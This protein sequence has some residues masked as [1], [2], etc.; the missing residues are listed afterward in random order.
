MNDVLAY[1]AK[2]NAPEPAQSTSTDHQRER[3]NRRSHQRGGGMVVDQP[4]IRLDSTVGTK[5]LGD[6]TIDSLPRG[7][8]AVVGVELGTGLVQEVPCVHDLETRPVRD[9]FESPRR[10]A[11][12]F[13]SEPSTPTTT[14]GEVAP[15]VT[16]GCVAGGR[17][18]RRG[19]AP[20]CEEVLT[21]Q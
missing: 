16:D 14:R 8:L 10:N 20:F 11:T 13:P 9:R 17:R 7:V 18:V 15:C 6:E 2:Q 1:G 5:G 4:H 3:T 12:R 21:G 19:P